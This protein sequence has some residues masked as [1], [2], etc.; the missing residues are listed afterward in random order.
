[1]PQAAPSRASSA[2][3]S[4]AAHGGVAA[5][6]P[7]RLILMLMDGALERIAQARGRLQHGELAEKNRL[8]CSAVEII[9]ELRRSLDLRAGGAIAA[10]LDD[11]Y[12]YMCRQLISANLQNRAAT[13]DEVSHLLREIRSAWITVPPEARNLRAGAP[14]E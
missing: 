2:Y 13:L 14:K 1:M 7:H 4:V 9:E 5:S 12:D 11:L 8:L 3:N 10:N 6:D